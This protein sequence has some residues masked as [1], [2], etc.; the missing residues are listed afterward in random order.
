MYIPRIPYT[1]VVVP[2]GAGNE[3]PVRRKRNVVD[4]LLVAMETGHWLLAR[5]GGIPQNHGQVITRGHY[6]LG[7]AR[8]LEP[9]FSLGFLIRIRCRDFIRMIEESGSERKVTRQCDVVDPMLVPGPGR[10]MLARNKREKKKERKKEKKE[11]KENT[12]DLTI[13]G[14]AS[15]QKRSTLGHSYRATPYRSDL[16]HSHHPPPT[17][18][19]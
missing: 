17:S 16:C 2:S 6:P 12:K 9:C 1:S 15:R 11:K 19:T 14:P 7:F 3:R 8:S 13:H 18:R 5:V 4:C 10:I